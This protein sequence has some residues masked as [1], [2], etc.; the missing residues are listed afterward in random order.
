M[1]VR[2]SNPPIKC[3]RSRGL[4]LVI[5]AGGLLV[6]FHA[7]HFCARYRRDEHGADK[8]F[9]AHLPQRIG[10]VGFLVPLALATIAWIATLGWL[11]WLVVAWLIS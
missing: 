4:K 1:L 7:D 3:W 8:T 10:L 2:A 6:R 11:T 5:W 9:R